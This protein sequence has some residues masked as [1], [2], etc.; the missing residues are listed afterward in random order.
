[1]IAS[2]GNVSPVGGAPDVEI[3]AVKVLDANNR[4]T[5]TSSVLAGLDYVINSVPDV[6]FVNMS[7]GTDARFAGDCDTET[8]FNIAFATAIGTL[9]TNGALSFVSTGNN[10]VDRGMQ[11]PACI[12]DAISVGAVWDTDQGSGTTPFCT[13]TGHG[14]DVITCFTN[15]SVATDVLG[16]GAPMTSTGLNG[17]TSTVFGTSF[18][19]SLITACAAL[20]KQGNPGLSAL[21]IE[22]RLK[23]SSVM[24]AD[25]RSGRTYPRTDC[26]Q[27]IQAT[28]TFPMLSISAPADGAVVSSGT[29]A[30]LAAVAIDAEDG[31]LSANIEWRD[32][33]SLLAT[34][35][36]RVVNF[37]NGAHTLEAQ[38]TDSAGVTTSKFIIITSES[39]SAP[40]V[41]ISSPA[42][43]SQVQ[44]GAVTT[45][46]GTATDAEDGDL[47]RII[48]WSDNE[49]VFGTG[50]SVSR[51]FTAGAHTLTATVTD[52]DGTTTST[53][54]DVTATARPTSGGGGGG[55]GGSIGWVACCL[56]LWLLCGRKRVL[57][58]L[59]GCE[60][61]PI[62]SLNARLS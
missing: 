28:N 25:P 62:S 15:R 39:R 13:D 54:V 17:G 6:N 46:S 2:A 44:V 56:L 33:G 43:G 20:L 14:P 7:L 5:T 45:I 1:M 24:V 40:S 23:T 8:A 22:A 16:P 53:S 30:D 36:T 4:F 37:S 42:D 47:S 11:S 26:L 51:N 35:G 10:S 31:D 48:D 19:N 58:K 49:S 50:G 3:V 12:A 18:A 32:N 29:T 34:G 9:R 41:T 38:V 55:G 60:R 52:N 59:R 61:V 57:S 27:A 21:A